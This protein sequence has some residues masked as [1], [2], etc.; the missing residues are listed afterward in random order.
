VL[1][2]VASGVNQFS[3]EPVYRAARAL[4]AKPERRAMRSTR[5]ESSARGVVLAAR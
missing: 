4:P 3:I 5:E 1:Q 2:G